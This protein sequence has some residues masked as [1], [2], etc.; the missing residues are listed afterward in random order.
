MTRLKLKWNT[1][2]LAL[3][4]VLS[5]VLNLYALNIEGYG[6]S[7]YAAAVKSMMMNWHNF[8]YNSF[9]PNGFITIDKPPVDFWIQT[10]FA[11]VFGFHGWVLV[12]PQAL[13]GVASVAVL[14]HLV[15]RVFGIPAG[16]IAAAVMAVTPIAVAVQRTNQVDGMLVLVMLLATWALLKAIETRKLRWLLFVGL[17]EGVG[18]N[19]KMMEAY[20][21]L[22]AIYL[23]YLFVPKVNWKKK[24]F[25]LAAMTAV[26]VVTSFSWAVA[27][28]LTPAS[29]RPYVGSTTD[30]SEI[31]LIF[32]YNGINRLTGNMSVGT[33]GTHSHSGFQR[34]SFDG[35]PQGA[36]G[37]FQSPGQ[38]S[39][40]SGS[41]SSG[42]FSPPSGG[43][44]GS[45]TFQGGSGGQSGFG[46]FQGGSGGPPASGGSANRNGNQR[47]GFRPGG[48]AGGPSGSAGMFDTGT[49]GV[50]RLFQPELGPQIGW[51]LPLALLAIIP[52]LRRV[53][54]RRSLTGK[55]LA[56]V[57]WAAWLLPMV[58][59]FSIAGF[60]HQYYLI[61]L[62]P[63]V[64]ALVGAG[65]V[66]MWKDF[67]AKNA[68]KHY[69]PVVFGLNV[70]FEL[71]TVKNYPTVRL[72]L[73]IGS[74]GAAVLASAFILLPKVSNRLK[75]VGV[76]LGI[77]SLL[78]TPGYWA[79]TPMLNGVNGV[80]PAA[81]PSTRQGPMG[82]SMSNLSASS[83]ADAKL[84]AF[85][86]KNYKASPGSY[87]LATQNAGSAEP[88]II[89][90]GLPVMAM[91]GFTGSDAAMTVS[92]LE[93]LTKAGKVKYFLIQGGN[94]FGGGGGSQASVT[95]W[96]LKHSKLV[97]T[98]EWQSTSST[99]AF[100]HGKGF[101]N[102]MGGGGS[103]YEYTG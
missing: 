63:G 54:W 80:M 8:F 33:T 48:F 82:G 97:P 12:L 38:T 15:K 10:I 70:L 95:E 99:S 102:G 43:Q 31:S 67:R 61:T 19:I 41:G 83:N 37:S 55:E 59:F 22:P 76:V 45:G 77:L 72:P 9:D 16:L 40:S 25:H 101:G 66:R 60:F 6:N 52:L 88:I 91:G 46:S 4:L 65:L 92:K 56:T 96:I 26:L 7:Y 58:V 79:L 51:L 18:F 75:A 100:G 3:I 44:T 32:G 64:A 47:G 1:W 68:W 11:W 17:L 62:A 98:S 74:L 81:G 24:I 39:S 53:R 21:I 84:I 35:F 2:V 93:Q 86:E 73:I 89:E 90:T 20:L 71:L 23:A 30:N 49:P 57:F 85:L 29:E 42:T 50:L 34:G 36:G 94:Q 5:S 14:Y 28:D 78:M 27:V 87:L 69:L 13:A 103:L